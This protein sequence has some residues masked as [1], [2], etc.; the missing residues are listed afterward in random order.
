MAENIKTKKN[1]AI[2]FIFHAFFI[3]PEGRSDAYGNTSES[4][5]PT[6]SP[7]GT[8]ETASR[9]RHYS[10]QYLWTKQG[11]TRARD[12]RGQKDRNGLAVGDDLCPAISQTK[13][14][15]KL[16]RQTTPRKVT[17]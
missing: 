9:I 10:T 12:K 5:Q 17:I 13:R 4:S 1:K 2:F 15:S 8:C 6:T 7:G 11:W 16:E 3:L 14:H